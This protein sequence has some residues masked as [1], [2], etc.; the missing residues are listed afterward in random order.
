MRIFVEHSSFFIDKKPPG[1]ARR[2]HFLLMSS[3]SGPPVRTVSRVR[4]WR[5]WHKWGGLFFSCFLIPFLLSGLV[6]NHREALRGVDVPRAYL[7]PSYRLHNW[8]QG[9]VRGTLPLSADCILLYGENGLFLSDARGEHIRPFN[10]GL[11]AGAENRSFGDAVRLPGGEVFAVSPYEVYV[12]RPAAS[13][14]QIATPALGRD[15][16]FVSAAVAGDTLVVLSRSAVYT[17]TAPYARFTRSELAAPTEGAPGRFT[18]RTIWRLHSGELFGE[19]GRFAVDALALCLLALCITGLILTFMPRLVRRWKIHRRRAANRFTL[20]SL[21][22]HNRIG[23]GTL[24]FVFV[25][26]LSGMFLRLP[27]LI[28]VA[29]GTHRPVPH[30]VEDVPNAWWD[31]LRMVRRDTARGEWLFYTA[32]GFYATPS[33]ALPPHRLRHEPPTGF[34][35]PNVLRQE[36]RDEWTVGSFA[37][38]YRWN[39]ATGECY[40]LMRCCR[41]VAPKRA[42]MPDFT[43]SVSG[44]STDLGVRAVVFDYNRG[45][46]FPVAIAYKA[47]TRDGSTGASAAAPM[48]AQS[49]A[50]SPASDRMS[51][52]RLALEVHTGRI[53]TFLPTLLVQL[54]IFLS[55][56]FL[57]SVVISGFVVY[58]RVFKRHKLANPK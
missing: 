27:L 31:E 5:R 48:P 3:P 25:L 14:W 22:W 17:A 40:D 44:Y 19:I 20:L 46:E 12:L 21:R 43:Y 26:T 47:P 13:R 7:P 34:M 58:R 29:G 8:N 54:F 56:L 16:R 24:V 57:L 30:T 6:L 4:R 50:V 9:T 45:A 55:G 51:L 15:D 37:G 36:N 42:G 2:G 32:H 52:W 10:E 49:S 39:R 38:L 33:L 28:L 1:C 11:R 35:G 53:Y 18:L 23:V 41:Y